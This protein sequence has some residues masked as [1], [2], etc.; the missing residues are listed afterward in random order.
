MFISK[1]KFTCLWH[2]TLKHLFAV[3]AADVAKQMIPK[4]QGFSGSCNKFLVDGSGENEAG[5]AKTAMKPDATNDGKGSYM[6]QSSSRPRVGT[7]RL[8]KQAVDFVVWV[9][10]KLQS[11]H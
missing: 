5:E 8:E 1:N 7:V 6:S 11:I 9:S 2:S 10:Q 4:R 3:H